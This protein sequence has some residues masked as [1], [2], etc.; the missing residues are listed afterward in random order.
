MIALAATALAAGCCAGCSANPDARFRH[1]KVNVIAVF[2]P[3]APSPDATIEQIRQEVLGARARDIIHGT[4]T[5]STGHGEPS[6]TAGDQIYLVCSATEARPGIEVQFPGPSQGD[7]VYSVR[8][9]L[10]VAIEGSVSVTQGDHTMSGG[11]P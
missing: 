8:G 6:I 5:E 3:S 4:V 2:D 10:V 1:I 11:Y 9:K 7:D